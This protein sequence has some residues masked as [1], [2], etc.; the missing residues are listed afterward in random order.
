MVPSDQTIIWFSNSYQDVHER[1]RTESHSQTVPRYN[2]RFLLS[3]ASC[4]AS[5]VVDDELN[6]LQI[7]SHIRSVLPVEVGEVNFS[8]FWYIINGSFEDLHMKFSLGFGV[9]F[10]KFLYLC[11]RAGNDEKDDLMTFSMVII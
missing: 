4:K 8:F 1:F 10:P 7:S 6:I 11:F 5:L 3:I 9:L 2:E